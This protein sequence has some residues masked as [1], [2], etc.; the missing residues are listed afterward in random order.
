M[1]MQGFLT[2][3]L[4][5]RHEV[6]SASSRSTIQSPLSHVPRLVAEHSQVRHI[7]Q[8]EWQGKQTLSNADILYFHCTKQY[9]RHRWKL[10]KISQRRYMH[11]GGNAHYSP[12]SPFQ[13]LNSAFKNIPGP[14][15]PQLVSF[16]L[17]VFKMFMEYKFVQREGRKLDVLWVAVQSLSS[18]WCSSPAKLS[19]A[20]W[21]CLIH[22][23]YQLLQ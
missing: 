2:M 18:E 10:L 6:S 21:G 7:L 1:V 20:L 15:I 13:R 5:E 22:C 9:N 11:F 3:I 8:V 17:Q 16:A 14:S 12:N 23:T 19:P 4:H